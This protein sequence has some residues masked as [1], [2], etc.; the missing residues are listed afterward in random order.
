MPQFCELCQGVSAHSCPDKARRTEPEEQ[1]DLKVV[2]GGGGGGGRRGGDK[3]GFG[4]RG[5]GEVGV[6]SCNLV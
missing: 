4:G 3:G 6:A 1:G 2:L 5:G